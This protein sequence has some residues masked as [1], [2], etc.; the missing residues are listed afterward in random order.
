MPSVAKP[1]W[2]SAPSCRRTTS[3]AALNVPGFR[4]GT[5]S[6]RAGDRRW[7]RATAALTDNRCMPAS[8]PRLLIV[9]TNCYVRLYMSPVR[10]LLGSVV[11]GFKLMTLTELKLE[12][13]L[14]SNVRERFPWMGAADI[15]ADLDGA[16]LKLREPK[17]G[18]IEQLARLT[19]TSGIGILATHCASQ[20]IQLV[21]ELSLTDARALAAADVLDASLATD[22]WP[23]RHVATAMGMGAPGRSSQASRCSTCWRPL[24]VSGGM[25]ASKPCAPGFS[26]PMPC[27]EAGR[28]ATPSCSARRRRT[29]SRTVRPKPETAPA[30]RRC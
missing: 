29:V 21:R 27:S 15:Q 23:L 4:A 25:N 13:S 3:R 30:R 7:L 2:S 6:R 28:R 9:D 17:K 18:K 24:G 20:G 10:P 12:S 8:K 1:G 19:R 11:G 16:C 22:E 14:R 26:R 5:Y